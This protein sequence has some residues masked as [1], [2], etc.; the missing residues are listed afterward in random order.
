MATLN[1]N[2]QT[3]ASANYDGGYN[4]NITFE[5]QA[6]CSQSIVGNYST[7]DTR[8]L[9]TN[10]V[11]YL[12]VASYSIGLSGTSDYTGSNLYIGIE[13]LTLRTGSYRVYHADNG[14]ASTMVGC[15][16]RASFG[17]TFEA[18][19][20]VTLP[21]IPRASVPSA[22][23]NP[24]VLSAT[25]NTLTVATNRKADVFTHTLVCSIG[26]YSETKTG[27]TTD[28][29]FSIPR[30][31]IASFAQD[32]NTL[33]GTIVCTTYNGS[34]QVGSAQ[35]VTFTAQ[36]SNAD[37][38]TISSVTLEDTNTK[39]Q[40][41][42]ASGSYIRNASNLRATIAFGVGSPYTELASAVIVCGNVTQSYTLSGSSQTIVFE[43]EKLNNTSLIITVYDERG[44][45]VT[46]TKTWN[47]VEYVDLTVTGSVD[48]L[49]E[50]GSRVK[51]TLQG[52]CFAGSFGQA[53]NSIEV[54]YKWKLHSD[55]TYTTGAETFT[56]TPSG[57]GAT[58]YEYTG[59]LDGFL[60]N[61]QYDFIFTV[62]DLFT[63]AE[64]RDITLTTGI[65]VWGAAS[66]FF[67]VYGNIHV[68]SRDNP[69]SYW[70]IS[71]DTDIASVVAALSGGVKVVEKTAT[72]S[73][74]NGQ[75]SINLYLAGYR[76]VSYVLQYNNSGSTYVA[77]EAWDNRGT[78]N[79]VISGFCSRN[80]WQIRCFVVYVK[81]QFVDF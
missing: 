58:T 22:S 76:A 38:P 46:Q 9:M 69:S 65:P 81:E 57:S 59:Q 32:S 1:S 26:S 28:T 62:E 34:T 74:P 4:Y 17:P 18:Y 47:L 35:T 16:Y 21:T 54:S 25:E 75:W 19:P 51:F 11:G 27:V 24:I 42:E 30:S 37:A 7:V 14:S 29:T 53:V 63:S 41:V 60:Y 50:T 70:T 6:K 77:A 48:R 40:A 61:R 66:D 64:T 33:N 13:T 45:S 72:T 3:I 67:A 43:Y 49:T 15:W 71:P 10:S 23:P 12:S 56:F 44:N 73:S 36:V 8:L 80:S 79:E 20:T 31:V 55:E 2:W 5:L 39:T 68:H 52:N 78:E